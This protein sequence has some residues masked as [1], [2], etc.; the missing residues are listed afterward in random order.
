M[1]TNGRGKM[2][3]KSVSV[4]VICISLKKTLFLAPW[5]QQ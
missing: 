2:F 3:D 5:K 1:A 4:F